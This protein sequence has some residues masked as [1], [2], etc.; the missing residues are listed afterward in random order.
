M[1]VG[2]EPKF[3]NEQN[4]SV[5]YT[6]F[7]INVSKAE[8]SPQMMKNSSCTG[9]SSGVEIVFKSKDSP[10]RFLQDV[11]N[12]L[13]DKN[14]NGG[15]FLQGSMTHFSVFSIEDLSKLDKQSDK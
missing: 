8:K 11:D 4:N 9:S 15:Q 12:E 2:N 5:K 14:L 13:F 3:M 1:I 7:Q 10:S 6:N